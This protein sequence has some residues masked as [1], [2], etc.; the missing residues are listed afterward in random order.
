MFLEIYDHAMKYFLVNGIRMAP[1]E[2]SKD[3]I[4]MRANAFP[5]QWPDT[6]K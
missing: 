1:R 6:E 4:R 2:F 5:D 3:V